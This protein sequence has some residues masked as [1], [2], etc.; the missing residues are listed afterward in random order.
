MP[1]S[2]ILQVPSRFDWPAPV[3]AWMNEAFRNR[4]VQQREGT[5][6]PLVPPSHDPPDRRGRQAMRSLDTLECDQMAMVA[7]IAALARNTPP[8]CQS[9]LSPRVS[10]RS[11][12][13][14]VRAPRRPFLILQASS[15]QQR[16]RRPKS[17]PDCDCR[18]LAALPRTA[19]SERYLGDA[20]WSPGPLPCCRYC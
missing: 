3:R 10:R 14:G 6:T 19:G 1:R 15:L 9:S 5:A 13:V 12:V 8:S 17:N 7:S 2:G 18:F 11:S 20:T 16:R 4:N